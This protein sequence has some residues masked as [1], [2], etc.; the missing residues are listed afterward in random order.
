MGDS[1]DALAAVRREDQRLAQ[2]LMT[3]QTRDD[4]LDAAIHA[5]ENALK[6]LSLARNADDKA[7]FRTRAKEFMGEAESIKKNVAWRPTSTHPKDVANASTISPVS[8]VAKFLR[9]PRST[10]TLTTREK[11][12][13]VRATFLNGT[14]FPMWETAPFASEFEL[15]EIGKLFVC[16]S[17]HV[18]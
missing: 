5:A 3:A 9:E 14:K 8:G 11:I 6:A 17:Q 18:A 4:A 10:R 13:L 7:Q 1:Q 15:T 16:V 2:K 12:I